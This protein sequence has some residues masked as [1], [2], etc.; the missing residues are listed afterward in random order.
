[1]MF[2]LNFSLSNF[3]TFF[4]F[5]TAAIYE[6]KIA[7]QDYGLCEKYN[8]ANVAIVFIPKKLSIKSFTFDSVNGR[9]RKVQKSVLRT[10]P[11]H[12]LF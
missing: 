2:G 12:L 9:L 4:Y 7:R 8:P 3:F 1:M 5:F 11:N 6:E 10:M